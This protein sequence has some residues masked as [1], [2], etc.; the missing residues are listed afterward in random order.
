[1]LR[2]REYFRAFGL[3][4]MHIALVLFSLSLVLFVTVVN[5]MLCFK[6]LNMAVITDVETMFLSVLKILF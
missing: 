1:M 6:S 2:C 3:D 5:L 4:L